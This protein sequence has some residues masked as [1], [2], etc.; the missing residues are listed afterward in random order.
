M[1]KNNKKGNPYENIPPVDL[2]EK[3]AFYPIT[4]H[5][6]KRVVF[7]ILGFFF[8]VT[9]I[10]ILVFTGYKAWSKINIHGR[11]II[12]KQII[13][14]LLACII[15]L[16]V[17]IFSFFR[18]RIYKSKG[19]TVFQNG[20]VINNGSKQ[21][22]LAWHEIETM[23]TYLKNINLGNSTVS[24]KPLVKLTTQQKRK[25]KILNQYENLEQLIGHIRQYVLP[26]LFH[27]ASN[28]LDSSGKIVFHPSIVVIKTGIKLKNNF[29]NW[30]DL[31]EPEI[32]RGKLIFQ[33]NGNQQNTFKF[34]LVSIKNLEVLLYLIKSRSKSKPIP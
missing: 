34:N 24:I 30:Q 31:H 2:G 23:D 25:F 26:I 28:N 12:I 5:Q 18:S 4:H 7:L 19:L 6:S 14:F 10:V 16:P 15:F 13:F 22:E 9:T 33:A 21:H 3:I 29:F 11:A 8:I 1:G 17:G 27:K 32:K 20:L